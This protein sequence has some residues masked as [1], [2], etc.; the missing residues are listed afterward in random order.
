MKCNVSMKISMTKN[1]HQ[2][3]LNLYQVHLIIEIVSRVRHIKR[4]MVKENIQN[5]S[6]VKYL[7]R[8]KRI[9]DFT[10]SNKEYLTE[11]EGTTSCHTCKKQ[12]TTC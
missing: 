12:K 7:H 11:K 8:L 9:F 6:Q 5:V 1:N 10:N 2:K 3:V 4:W